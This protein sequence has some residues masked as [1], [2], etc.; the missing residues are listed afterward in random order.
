M[1]EQNPKD[2]EDSNEVERLYRRNSLFWGCLI[3]IYVLAG[4]HLGEELSIAG[5]KVTFSNPMAMEYSMLMVALY[6]CWRHWL[7]SRC[8]RI[9][10][11]ETLYKGVKGGDWIWNALSAEYN[12]LLQSLSWAVEKGKSIPPKLNSKALVS[13]GF[14]NL[15]Y[16]LKFRDAV[17]LDNARIMKVSL[18][19]HP[20]IFLVVSVK[21][22]LS[23]IWKAIT[24][25]Y[26]GDGVLP[27]MVTFIAISLY[28]MK[29]LKSYI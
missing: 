27:L 17:S 16:Q 1:A 22:R 20:I 8:I 25:T 14:V 13:V 4:G 21:Y 6:F 19:R 15:Q 24:N 18:F 12:T 26:F 7:V 11:V 9:K 28:A 23:W 29:M 2:A 10:L 3:V 5:A